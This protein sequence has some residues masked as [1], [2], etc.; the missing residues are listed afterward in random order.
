MS[1]LK[2]D[3]DSRNSI[4][5]FSKCI[6][7][8]VI[9]RRRADYI[10]KTGK[11]YHVMFSGLNKTNKEITKLRRILSDDKKRI[12]FDLSK[13]KPKDILHEGKTVRY[14]DPVAPWLLF[15]NI[16]PKKSDYAVRYETEFERGSERVPFLIKILQ[17]NLRYGA[18][19]DIYMTDEQCEQII[20]YS[21]K[22]MKEEEG[23]VFR[24]TEEELNEI[25][26]A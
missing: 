3:W 2:L 9:L 13:K 24:F 14:F 22:K 18:G 11:G 17:K 5:I 12:K 6:I 15:S 16:I 1:T 26:E 21:R 19:G 20:N 23:M 8:T 4:L 10:L 25:E 7:S